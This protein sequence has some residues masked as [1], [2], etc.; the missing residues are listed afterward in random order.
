MAKKLKIVV[1]ITGA[2]GSIYAKVL[3]EKLQQMKS[4]VE[5]VGV[6]M[7]DNAKEVWRTELGENSYEKIKF[8]DRKS[9]RLNSSHIQKSRMPSSA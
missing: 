5:E 4:Q 8:R 2:S 6:V 9:T 7:S 3:L 1:G